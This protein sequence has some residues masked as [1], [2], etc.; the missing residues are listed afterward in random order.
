V[1]VFVFFVPYSAIAASCAVF[2]YI[3]YVL[4]TATGFFAHGKTWTD[5]GPWHLGKWYRPLAFISVIGCGG[6]III[7]IQPPNEIAIKILGGTILLMLIAW[8]GFERK[9]F[10]GPPQFAAKDSAASAE[11]LRGTTLQP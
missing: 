1:L 4:P 8:F 7:G 10:R 9:R 6:L 5:M 11:V 2:L 3:S